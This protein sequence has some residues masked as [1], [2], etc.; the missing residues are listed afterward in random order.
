MAW[1]ISDVMSV[2]VSMSLDNVIFINPQLLL[3]LLNAQKF[4]LT[5]YANKLK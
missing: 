3:S 2:L 1:L 4:L 5:Q